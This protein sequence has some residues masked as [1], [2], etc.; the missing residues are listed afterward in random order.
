M[1]MNKLYNFLTYSV[2]KFITIFMGL[3]IENE[4]RLANA[5]NCII[6]ANHISMFDPPFIGS[7]IPLEIHYLAKSEI[8]KNKLMD[9]FF[10]SIN[11]IPVKR[12]R[13]DKYAITTVQKL[14]SSGHSLL[15]FPEGT[16]NGGKAKA[17]VGK[18]AIQMKVDILPIHIENSNNFLK[19]LLKKTHLHIIVGEKYKYEE[20]SHLK[21]K[22]ENYRELAN[23]VYEKIMDL[24]K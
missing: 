18:F 13:I 4:Q 1:I 20:F 3:K 15:I 2:R 22:K 12:G 16:R 8:F 23:T 6:V 5:E 7:I 21:E 9:K 19:C 10:R 14:L 11:A 17:G 24:K